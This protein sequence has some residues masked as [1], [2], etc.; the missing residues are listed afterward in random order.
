MINEKVRS[1]PNIPGKGGIDFTLIPRDGR[2]RF[3]TGG[4]GDR[5]VVQLGRTLIR[6]ETEKGSL[7]GP[8]L[9][10]KA[11]SNNGIHMNLWTK[12]EQGENSPKHPDMFARE[13]VAFALSYFEEVGLLITRFHA[14]WNPISDNYALY[15]KHLALKMSRKDA[16]MNTWTGTTLS[17]HGFY[18]QKNSDIKDEGIGL[19]SVYFSRQ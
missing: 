15:R 13:F 14:L 11:Y 8:H 16:A 12:L 6:V 3:V 9:E 7:E 17:S 5:L 2:P 18:V 10:A 4:S 19:V 1:Y